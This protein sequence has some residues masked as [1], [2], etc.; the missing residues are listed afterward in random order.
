MMIRKRMRWIII[1]REGYGVKKNGFILC[2]IAGFG[3][4]LAVL[5]SWLGV[6]IG[7]M[8]SVSIYLIVLGA[9]GIII[10]RI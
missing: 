7:L 8:L 4:L 1:K 3:L 2:L 10:N 5:V 9:I 6:R